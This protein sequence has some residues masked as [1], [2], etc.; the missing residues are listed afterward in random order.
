MKLFTS[1]PSPFG[2]KAR[3]AAGMKGLTG[4]IEIVAAEI[5]RAH[6]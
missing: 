4:A 5:G 1:P 6:V 3:I 2:R